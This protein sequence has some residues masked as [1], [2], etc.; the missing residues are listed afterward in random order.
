[1]KAL[2]EKYKLTEYDE[3]K[4]R[5]LAGVRYEMDIREF[6]EFNRYVFARAVS[7]KTVA[8]VSEY[9]FMLPGVLIE[10]ESARNYVSGT[11]A[12]HVLGQVG[13]IYAEEYKKLKEKGYYMNDLVGKSG[14]ESAL[15][16]KLRGENGLFRV[17]QDQSGQILSEQTIKA[18]KPGNSVILTIDKGLQD[19]ITLAIEEHAQWLKD[20]G[21]R[22]K[23]MRCV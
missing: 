14:I 13:P 3:A 15:E 4:A 11:T 22:G 16:D 6:G 5:K 2:S 10:Q 23:D 17:V 21:D 12:P 20:R 1:M 7:S 19:F 18:A 8:K 9:N